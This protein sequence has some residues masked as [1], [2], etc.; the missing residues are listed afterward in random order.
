MS[1][2]LADAGYRPHPPSS[3]DH[4]TRLWQRKLDTDCFVTW[5]EW[6]AGSIAEQ[7]YPPVAHFEVDC[8]AE[9]PDGL[10]AKV[11]LYTIKEGAITPEFV[12]RIESEMLAWWRTQTEASR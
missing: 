3:I 4:C 7:V 5:N 8:Y 9:R 6:A 11:K 2:V 1:K 12:A 10:T